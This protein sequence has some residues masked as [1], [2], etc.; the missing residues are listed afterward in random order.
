MWH[1][2]SYSLNSTLIPFKDR[3]AC[4]MSRHTI[5]PKGSLNMLW[6]WLV[7]WPIGVSGVH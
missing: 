1:D 6:L 3:V 5:G 2:G 4:V 7:L